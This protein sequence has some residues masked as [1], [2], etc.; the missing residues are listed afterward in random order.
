MALPLPNQVYIP[1]TSSSNT[2][3]YDD[4]SIVLADVN[5]DAFISMKTNN[6]PA[7]LIDKN[8]KIA[9]NTTSSNISAQFNI[10]ASSS[11]EVLKFMRQN[12][13]PTSFYLDPSGDLTV[14]ISGNKVYFTNGLDIMNHT[15]SEPKFFL[16]GNSVNATAN[17][18]NY[19]NTIEGNAVASKALVVNS[20]KDIYGIRTLQATSIIGTLASGA[21][22]NITSVNQIDIQ[23]HDGVGNGLRLNGTLVLSTADELNYTNVANLG[24]AEA[25]KALV[26]DSSRTII[27]IGSLS[28]NTLTGTLLTGP[29]PNIT[30]IGAL[31]SLGVNG[32]TGLGYAGNNPDAILDIKTINNTDFIRLTDT[33]SS[34][35]FA[36]IN[37]TTEGWLRFSSNTENI[38]VSSNHN[39]KIQT[40]NGDDKGLWLNNVLVKAS[41]NQLNYLTVTPGT[42]IA[43]KALVVDSSKRIYGIDTLQAEIII[44]TIGTTYQPHINQV[45]SLD[46]KIHNGVDK[47]L[48]L[49]GTLVKSSASDINKLQ[50]TEGIVS[51]SKVV[52]A[53]SSRNINNINQLTCLELYGTIRSSTQPYINRVDNLRIALHDGLENGLTLGNVLVVASAQQLNY[54]KVVPGVAASSKT[55]VLN[56]N[57]DI[58]NINALS[59]S[60]LAGTL[61]TGPQPNI[62]SV[63]TLNITGHNG[64]T[65]GLQLNGT[66]VLTTAAELNYLRVG[67]GAAIPFKALIM[68]NSNSIN[69][70]NV[71]S[72]GFLGGTITT[73]FQP[74]INSVNSLNIKEHDGTQ[75]GLRLA[76]V[77]VT[78][79]ASK[80]NFIDVPAGI[81][82]PLK[83][84]VLDSTSNINGINQ[85]TASTIIGTIQTSTQPN[86][87]QVN[88]LNIVN[89]D[90]TTGLRLAGILVACT[91][92]QLNRNISIEGIA[93]ASKTLT[94]D[95]QKNITGI[96]QLTATTI[97][98]TI[99]TSTQ[100]N[101]NQVNTLNIANHNG[102]TTGLS[103]NGTLVTSTATQLNYLNGSIGNALPLTALV[104]DT[105]RSITNINALTAS[106]LTG[107]LLTGAQPNIASVSVLNITNHNG[108]TGLSLNGQLVSASAAQ[109]N[110]TT[111]IPGSA[112]PSKALILNAFGSV[113]GVNTFGATKVNAETLE[114]SGVIKNLNTGAL[115]MRIYSSVDFIGRVIDSQL[116]NITNF[117]NL[118]FGNIS[119]NFSME[120]IGYILPQYSE[121]YTFF[122]QCQGRVRLWVN[123]R[124]VLCSWTN[125]SQSRTSSTI[126]LNANIWYS[127][128]IQYQVDT[129]ASAFNLEWSSSSTLRGGIQ[130]SRLAWDDRLPSHSI[131]HHTQNA[132]VIYNSSTS[133]LNQTSFTV[134][135]TGDL[136]IDSSGNDIRFGFNDNVDIASHD[137]V[138]SGLYLGGQLVQ[139]TAFEL[140]YLKVSPGTVTPSHALVVDGTSSITGLSALTSTSITCTNLTASNFTISN[141]SLTGPLSNLNVGG[142]IIK[143]IM[144]SNLSGR[145]V[146][147]NVTTTMSLVDYDPK[148]LNNNFSLELS[149]Y[150][151]PQ[152]TENYVFYVTANDRARIWVDDRLI[153]NIWDSYTG[154]EYASIP[155]ALV[156]NQWTRIYIQFQ[157][158]TGSSL[159]EIKWSSQSTSKNLINAS[160]LAWDNKQFNVGN[161][162]TSM[163]SITIV[164]SNPSIGIQSGSISVDSSGIMILGTNGSGMVSTSS[165]TSF[166]ISSHNT[167]NRGLMLNGVLVT[168]NANEL[169]YLKDSSF[170]IGGSGK[171][172]ILDNNRSISNINVLTATTLIGTL[173]SGP[174]PNITS[175]GTMTSTFNVNADLFVGDLT[176]TDGRIRF[177]TSNG[178]SYLQT[179]TSNTINSTNDFMIGSMN[180]SLNDSARRFMIKSNGFVGIQTSLPN[181]SL[182]INASGNTY[183]LRL[184]HNNISG[185]ESSGFVDM[186]SDATGNL[187]I[188]PN[189]TSCNILS[190]IRIGTSVDNATF[191]VNSTSLKM[192]SSSGCIQIGNTS[193]ANLPLEIGSASFSM[194]SGQ[195]GYINASGSTGSRS[196]TSVNTFS[197]RTTGRIIVGGEVDIISDRRSKKNITTLDVSFCKKFIETVDAVSFKYN[198]T[199]E[200][201]THYGY[202]AQDIYK[203]GY[204]NL[205]STVPDETIEEII[206][207]DGFVNPKNE[208]FVL[209][210]DEIIPIMSTTIKDLYEENRILKETVSSLINEIKWIKSKLI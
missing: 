92:E 41:A 168:A 147:V 24:I 100:P 98:G 159:L 176:N 68:D 119:N 156:A 74:F 191:A 21:Q 190:N 210:Y 59:A 110:Y 200:D 180:A 39:F 105:N 88:T 22:P 64:N 177:A 158:I 4:T 31:T 149:G 164:P 48:S 157:N 122:I 93:A 43:S 11:N 6:K 163:D 53:D 198:K 86:I 207:E 42:A 9:I 83:A 203:A 126:F 128:Y 154:L 28:A 16:G 137:G 2:L 116:I 195:Y 201:K 185:S 129:T 17:Q 170:G 108:S 77:L 51:A 73:A 26:L 76:G 63:T 184:I 71:L 136:L 58:T 208:K 57:R 95:A 118:S 183:G 91:A 5:N 139:P 202:I 85:L 209:C 146:D 78:A 94:L 18:L 81:G 55:L 174:Q 169:N 141:L 70:I 47:G 113:T 32:K 123:N 27:G 196:D 109:L 192:T 144:G 186:G 188:A 20:Q 193:N 49:N 142:L 121:S 167:I 148:G 107:T 171:V 114:V 205:V 194:S 181:R 29:Q 13:V 161:R 178:V 60:T 69:G 23:Q 166:N 79:S 138:T 130:S 199:L 87:N 172:M 30:S 10:N 175:I 206:D 46:I 97:V 106:T 65:A 204:E 120:I 44:S 15:S 152:F 37:L 162:L 131:N 135:N 140:N 145:I 189:G 45:D 155:I 165:D 33:I 153:L 125:I 101:I 103:L 14:D 1:A 56:D 54:N 72:A 3:L 115:R 40:H 61:L 102:N 150:V 80:I 111:A 36:S 133:G 99:Q 67:P 143:Q 160:F 124:L 151:L 12:A 179:S 187:N 90:G 84:L 35:R 66:L 127:I 132:M 89:H 197:L 38:I 134:D 50:V 8:Q 117:G 104:V 7:L 75:N 62:T 82:L 25:N 96:N 182:S 112:F 173:S 34:T 19:V 52:I